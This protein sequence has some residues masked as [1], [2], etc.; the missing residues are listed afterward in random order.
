MQVKGAIL[1]Y[2]VLK[3]STS[4]QCLVILCI[5]CAGNYYG[6]HC[7][8]DGEVLAVAIGASVAA[9]VIIG[10]TLICLCMWR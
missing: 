8:I 7:D 3:L 1:I 9:V 10:L 6:A 2:L 4:L 5:R